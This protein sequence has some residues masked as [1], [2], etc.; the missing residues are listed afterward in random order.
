MN[1]F[2]YNQMNKSSADSS[3]SE[4]EEQLFTRKDLV[5]HILI[6]LILGIII[7][8]FIKNYCITTAE[9]FDTYTYVE[10]FGIPMVLITLAAS[11]LGYQKYI[12]LLE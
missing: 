11:E 7:M 8:L 9:S 5:G 12:R 2:R 10:A 4:Q 3:N 1:Q 6:F